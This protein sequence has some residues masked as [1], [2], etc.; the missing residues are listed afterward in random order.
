MLASLSKFFLLLACGGQHAL[1]P[2]RRRPLRVLE[3]EQGFERERLGHRCKR[4]ER[5]KV[6]NM[7]YLLEPEI[8]WCAY[9]CQTIVS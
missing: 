8:S 6:V 7:L 3:D 5:F 9:Q 1:Q 2:G 4:D